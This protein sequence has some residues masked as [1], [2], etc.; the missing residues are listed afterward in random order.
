MNKK[1]KK[2]W[3]KI[4]F[5]ICTISNTIVPIILITISMISKNTNHSSN[6]NV[7]I[8][9]AH[10]KNKVTPISDW[11]YS[12]STYDA[13]NDSINILNGSTNTSPSSG[14]ESNAQLSTNYLYNEYESNQ[15]S[16][17]LLR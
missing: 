8:P 2:I 4:N 17:K 14:I 7:N 13:K 9:I 10:Y 3:M 16:K 5:K 12:F 6:S 15:T 11:S 1:I